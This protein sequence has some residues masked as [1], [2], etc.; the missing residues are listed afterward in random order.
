MATESNLPGSEKNPNDFP[1][2]ENLEEVMRDAYNDEM[3]RKSNLDDKASNLI[4]HSAE[5]AAIYGSIG[6]ITSTKLFNDVQL[7]YPIVIL[8]IG[9]SILVSSIIIS[10]KSHSL[11][12]YLLAV[13]PELFVK[14][15]DNDFEYDD[16]KIDDFRKKSDTEFHHFMTKVYINCL[17]KNFENNNKKAKELN[18]SQKTFYI[19]VATI[20]LFILATV[21]F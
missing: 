21:L 16:K 5:V 13:Q 2:T 12:D 10:A 3:N 19:G 18:I 15:K 9:V 7:N 17:R 14:S 4:F 20:P 8:L 6:L 1:S 11:R